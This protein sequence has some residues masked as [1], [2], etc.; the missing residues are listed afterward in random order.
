[1]IPLHAAFVWAKRILLSRNS[2]RR[3]K[4]VI[5]GIL[6]VTLSLIPFFVA[7]GLVDGMTRGISDRYT[8]IHTYHYQLHPTM[9]VDNQEVAQLIEELQDIP[10]ISVATPIQ[11]SSALIMNKGIQGGVL[12][13]GI[14]EEY[15]TY[16]QGFRSTLTI[17]HGTFEVSSTNGVHTTVISTAYAEELGVAVGETVAIVTP[18]VAP[19][20]KTFLKKSELII[21]GTFSTGYHALGNNTFYISDTLINQLFPKLQHTIGIKLAKYG[22]PET[23]KTL[24]EIYNHTASEWRI[25]EWIE[26]EPELYRNFTTSK[27]LLQIV[28]VLIFLVASINIS[29]TILFVGLDSSDDVTLM[30]I[31]G[32]SRRTIALTFLIIGGLIGILGGVAGVLIG[33]ILSMNITP[34]IHGIQA[35]ASVFGS[36]NTGL[37]FYLTEI[38]V[39]IDVSL[40]GITF[41]GV[42]GLAL[43][44]SLVPARK[45]SKQSITSLLRKS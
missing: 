32:V 13:R 3:R 9:A 14:S 40:M 39:I 11:E 37:N 28:M 18:L 38:P 4:Q 29:T 19:N 34:I 23:M 41:F 15:A 20:G 8:E 25:Y 27:Q 7:M 45:I 6:G 33:L 44:F 42:V 1:M 43:L 12:L 36:R 17:D 31:H 16:D 22:S 24:Q 2:Q 21:T 5:R 26:L 35:V 30:M 10:S